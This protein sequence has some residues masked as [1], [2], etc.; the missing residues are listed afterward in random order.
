MISVVIPLYNKEASIKQSLMSVL[1]QSYQNF[2]VVIVDDGSTDNSVA[3]VEEIQDSRI[4]LIRQK[5]GGPSKARNTGVKNAKGEWILFLDADD[6]FLPEALLNFERAIIENPSIGFICAPFYRRIQGKTSFA[7]SYTEKIIDNPFKEYCLGRLFP[8]TGAF[9]CK[10]EQCKQFLFDERIRRFEDLEWLFN[11]YKHV[12]VLTIKEPVL[13]NNLSFSAAS[14]AR[15]NI[16]EDFLGYL[17]FK[18]KSF[19]EKM[20]LYSFFLGE[21][22]YYE[23]QCKK[24]YPWLYR[25]YDWLFIYKVIGWMKYLC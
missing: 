3:K 5:N 10:S 8:R 22:E 19:W 7:Y 1:S 12:S 25:R 13:M 14:H 17:D 4:R 15:K 20:A 9:V 11:I 6:E 24:L 16:K 18:G 2:E 23:E 21:R